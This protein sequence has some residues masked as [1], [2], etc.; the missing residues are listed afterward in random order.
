MDRA[1]IC[2]AGKGSRMNPITKIIA[3]ELLPLGTRPVLDFIVDEAVASGVRKILFIINSDKKSIPL[4][5]SEVV[6]EDYNIS[7][8]FYPLQ[9]REGVQAAYVYQDEPKGTGD[10][11]RLAE[12]F[13]EGLPFGLMY[14]DDITESDTPCLAQLAALSKKMSDASVLVVQR[15]PPELAALYSTVV[16]KDFNGSYGKV[17]ELNEKMDPDKIKSDLTSFGRYVL[18]KDIFEY[19]NK[20]EL[21][22]GE[23]YLT[24]ALALLS[25]DKDVYAYLFDGVRY[26][27]G[28]PRGYA[29]TFKKLCG[30]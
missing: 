5:F 13:C 28:N 3:K 6:P 16:S 8:K 10:A 23:Y 30:F 27:T 4:Y 1:V 20:V 15:Q 11:V 25:R 2:V 19:I 17:D 12:K 29:D 14:G 24:D 22:K 7:G 26:D 21:R 9:G 18:N